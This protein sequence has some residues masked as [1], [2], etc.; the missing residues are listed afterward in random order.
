MPAGSSW[1]MV[2][3]ARLADVQATWLPEIRALQTF[4]QSIEKVA[5]ACTYPT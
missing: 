5:Q 1:Q 4:F 2:S 3:Q